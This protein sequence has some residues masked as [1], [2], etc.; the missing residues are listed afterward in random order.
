MCAFLGHSIVY[1]DGQIMVKL[2]TDMFQ[3]FLALNKLLGYIGRGRIMF[4]SLS[5]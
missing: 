3:Y 1:S 2:H 4:L 5:K